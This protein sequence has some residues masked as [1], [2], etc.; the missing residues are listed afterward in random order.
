MNINQ[1]DNPDLNFVGYEKHYP[2]TNDEK[3]VTFQKPE[4]IVD[5]VAN[6]LRQSILSGNLAPGERINNAELTKSLGVSIVPFREALRIL[7]NEG[8]IVSHSSRGKW[9][10]NITRD[11]L[12]ETFELREVLEMSALD[13]IRKHE[14]AGRNVKDKLKSLALDKKSFSLSAKLCAS[15]HRSLIE[16]AENEK[17]MS[18]YNILANN[19][20]RYQEMCYTIYHGAGSNMEEHLAEHSK[21]LDPLIKGDYKQAKTLLRSHLDSLKNLLLENVKFS[22]KK[23]EG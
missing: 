5:A 23:G 7:E 12:E 1:K 18:I 3:G 17:L 10:A 22:D 14:E 11:D 9:I 15:F 16:L 8:L 6:F 13:L 2:D 21:I 4:S 19:I 20:Q